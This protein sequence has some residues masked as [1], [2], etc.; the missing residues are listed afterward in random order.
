MHDF[1]FLSL[2]SHIQHR[3]Q[4]VK[5]C[6][7]SSDVETEIEFTEN[8]IY[9]RKTNTTRLKTVACVTVF[10]F[11]FCIV[12][13]ALY[14]NE[15]LKSQS[16]QLGQIDEHNNTRC[17]SQNSSKKDYGLKPTKPSTDYLITINSVIVQGKTLGYLLSWNFTLNCL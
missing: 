7:T 4:A 10:L 17:N 2:W 3:M 15:K 11:I 13:A 5:Y 16:Y 12:L 6:K 14:A 1:N 8:G 9:S